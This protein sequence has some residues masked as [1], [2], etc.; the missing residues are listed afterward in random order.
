M[1]AHTR[2]AFETKDVPLLVHAPSEPGI[3][4]T[5]Y[6][7][8]AI[9]ELRRRGMRFDFLLLEDRRMQTCNGYCGTR[10]T[11]FLINSCLAGF[12]SLAVEGMYYGKPV[13]GY[14]IESVRAEHY[15]DCP[16]VNATIDDLRDK[17]AWLIIQPK[18][19]CAWGGR[20]G[21]L[22]NDTSIVTKLGV[23]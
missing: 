18:N 19:A 5:E 10:R 23:R 21:N 4:G 1:C 12:G 13:V 22:W 7:K 17:L 11:L 9:E 14:L 3:K 2:R 6:V 16:I 20:E 8:V 15:P